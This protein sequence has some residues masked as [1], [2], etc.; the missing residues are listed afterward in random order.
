MHSSRSQVQSLKWWAS[1]SR[2]HRCTDTHNDIETASEDSSEEDEDED[3]DGYLATETLNRQINTTLNAIKSKDPRVYDA[4]TSF[5][6]ETRQERVRNVKSESNIEKPFYLSDYQRD[7]ILRGADGTTQSKN[8]AFTQQEE[9]LREEVAR[10][11]HQVVNQ[12]GTDAQP[13]DRN[14][15]SEDFLVKIAKTKSDHDHQD[16]HSC[17]TRADVDMADRDPD[18]FLSKFLSSRAWVP[19]PATQLHAFIS[20]DDEEEDQAEEYEAT[21]NLRFEDPEKANQKLVS[22][23]RQIA[24]SSSVRKAQTNKR[25]R[26]RQ[27][28][29]SQK[30]ERRV[31]EENDRARLRDLRA[32]EMT[33]RLA[34]IQEAYGL[35]GTTFNS[36]EWVQIL[37]QDWD[38]QQWESFMKGKFGEQH[39]T[40]IKSQQ[41]ASS[42]EPFSTAPRKPKWENDID[43]SDILSGGKINNANASDVRVRSNTRLGRQEVAYAVDRTVKMDLATEAFSNRPGQFRYRET[44]P[45]TFGLTPNDILFASDSQLNQ[46]VGLKK[47]APFRETISKRRDKKRL[48]KKAR[49]RQ[50]RADTFGTAS[51]SSQAARKDLPSM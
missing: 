13:S 7:A 44:S 3:E 11:M 33:R 8:S 38:D 43:I 42:H 1:S 46:Y 24:A 5:Y 27:E 4:T 26:A 23:S 28:A 40:V 12:T 30:S 31:A 48:E 35:Q 49:L 51:R 34:E 16:E 37:T 14:E 39:Y 29:G 17:L 47:L 36:D 18:A 10:Q 20:D 22:H 41:G 19:T 9:K 2:K 25:K 32:E 45:T 15:D 21:Y 50:W 6:N